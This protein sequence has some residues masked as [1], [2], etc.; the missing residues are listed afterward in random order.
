MLTIRWCYHLFEPLVLMVNLDLWK[1]QSPET[2]K[3]IKEAAKEALAWGNAKAE[4]TAEDYLKKM[5]A[6]GIQVTR[7][8]PEQRDAWFEYGVKSWDKFEEVIGKETMD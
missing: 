2:Q 5:A 8:T 3:A 7:L 1:E 6:E 4:E